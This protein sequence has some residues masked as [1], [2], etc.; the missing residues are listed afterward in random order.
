MG[1]RKEILHPPL[2]IQTL[3]EVLE[4]LG[5]GV[6]NERILEGASISVTKLK[7]QSLGEL[8]IQDSETIVRHSL[9]VVPIEISICMTGPG[10]VWLIRIQT[11]EQRLYLQAD[12]PDRTAIVVVSA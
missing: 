1:L 8:T 9:G 10:Q 12:A 4:D 2:D 6:G 7:R 11:N 3:N 5:H